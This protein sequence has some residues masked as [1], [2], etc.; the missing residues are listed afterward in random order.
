MPMVD[1]V[2]VALL[3]AIT[4]AT[5]DDDHP[6]I[7]LHGRVAPRVTAP[8]LAEKARVNG[9]EAARRL[10]AW[11]RDGFFA[12]YSLH[13][14]PALF[15]AERVGF[16]LRYADARRK[17]VAR[18][19]LTLLEGALGVRNFLGLSLELHVA[20][21]RVDGHDGAV[22]GIRA[23][24]DPE[25]VEVVDGQFDGRGDPYEPEREDWLL[26][27]ALLDGPEKGLAQAAREAG[28]PVRSARA[29]VVR[30]V[31]QGVLVAE[32]VLD[33]GHAPGVFV[34]VL[35]TPAAGRAEEAAGAMTR[36]IPNALQLTRSAVGVA[37]DALLADLA[38]AEAVASNLA[39]EDAVASLEILFP[40]GVREETAWHARRIG[41]RL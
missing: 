16:A 31:Q 39:R 9:R 37:C 8:L 30:L 10:A 32:P 22:D 20:C 23:L 14:H 35:V 33:L 2:D 6:D 41:E 15:G 3:H 4:S 19:R 28:V 36:R 25:S 40:L 12:G 38:Q 29:R 7:V 34:R 13:P 5:G 24:A 11:S 21:P 1:R 17:A 27:L 18:D 26:A